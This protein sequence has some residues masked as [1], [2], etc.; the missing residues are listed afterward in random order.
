MVR[1]Q[2]QNAITDLN[3]L[4]TANTG[5]SQPFTCN[6]TSYIGNV[7][8]DNSTTPYTFKVCDGTSWV[9]V[10]YLD[11]SNHIV[12]P[13]TGRGA[14]Q[15][16][17]AATTTDLGSVPQ[18]CISVTGN[19]S[20]SI[21]SLGSS[22]KAGDIKVLV[23]QGTNTLVYNATSLILPNGVNATTAAGDT[24]LFESQGSGN[25]TAVSHVGL[26]PTTATAPP[27]TGTNVSSTL[28][29]AATSTT[30][31]A[32]GYVV[33]TALSGGTC[34]NLGNYSQTFNSALTGAGGMDTGVLP[35]SGFVCIY[36]IYNPSTATQSILGTNCATSSTTIYG[37][38]HLPSGYTASALLAA[39]P[40][41]STP[42]MVAG[43]IF[44][45][46]FVYQQSINVV[47]TTTNQ[48]TVTAVSVSS[49][50]PPN[51]KAIANGSLLIATDG[52]QTGG[53][54]LI[55]VFPTSIGVVLNSLG[56]NVFL[57]NTGVQTWSVSMGP[58][59]ITTP[60][61]LYYATS[62]IDSHTAARIYI[63]SYMW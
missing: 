11:T 51:A 56:I 54:A 61:T 62:G 63:S 49:A 26:T 60:Q 46:V 57:T 17:V 9:P 44:G 2:F 5:S 21:T 12:T 1:G 36:A 38:T 31:T 3:R 37:G 13:P 29:A 48:P 52:S 58:L 16:I 39:W 47:N 35:S 23:F 30:V 55:A 50:V 59:G 22:A 28:N 10:Y 45:K 41:N 32:D 25:W 27:G 15:S 24:W 14:C 33:C 34:Y 6:Q 19:S 8:I 18:S 40:T 7:W 42:A 4:F 43:A 20:V 53:E